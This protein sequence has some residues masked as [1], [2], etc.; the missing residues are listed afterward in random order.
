MENNALNGLHREMLDR[1][2]VAEFN[3]EYHHLLYRRYELKER[4]L[5]LSLALSAVVVFV[6]IKV[7]PA[8]CWP[9]VSGAITLISTTVVPILRWNRLMPR[10][11]AAALRWAGLRNEYRN[12]WQDSKM[13]GDWDYALIELKKLRKK[14]GTVEKA[15]GLL[16]KHDDLLKKAREQVIAM[17]RKVKQ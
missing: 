11:E 15:D 3:T 14:D 10:I 2:F 1:L 6:C 12:L 17:H 4:L 16:P 7:F 8:G 13:S 9:T 5:R